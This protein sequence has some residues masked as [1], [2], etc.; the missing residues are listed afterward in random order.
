M[1]MKS[2]NERSKKIIRTSAVGMRIQHEV[3]KDK[4]AEIQSR[5][6]GTGP[7][8]ALEI[9]IQYFYGYGVIR[10]L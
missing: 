6:Q 4:R 1:A 7:I 5:G 9:A 10:V 8:G 2:T 3:L